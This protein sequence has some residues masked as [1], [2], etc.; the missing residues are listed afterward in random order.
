MERARKNLV[1]YPEE[2]AGIR[3]AFLCASLAGWRDSLSAGSSVPAFPQLHE[4]E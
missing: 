1:D 3:V 4:I 2:F